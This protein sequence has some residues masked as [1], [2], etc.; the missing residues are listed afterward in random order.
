MGWKHCSMRIDECYER[1]RDGVELLALKAGDTC[2]VALFSRTTADRCHHVLL[3]TPRAVE[4]A[5]DALSERWVECDDPYLFEWDLVV[6][7]KEACQQLGL[8]RPQF[9]RRPDPSPIIELGRDPCGCQDP[10]VSSPPAS[11]Q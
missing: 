3:L 11:P 2:D 10:P 8:M 1:V 4:L 9:G 6:G 5:A 7:P